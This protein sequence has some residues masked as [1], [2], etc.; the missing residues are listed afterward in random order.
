VNR[1]CS[2]APAHAGSLADF[3]LSSTLKMEAIRSSETSVNTLS[4]EHVHFVLR[5]PAGV[6]LRRRTHGASFHCNTVGS[7]VVDALWT[8]HVARHATCLPLD[9]CFRPVNLHPHHGPE[10]D[11]PIHFA[12]YIL[13]VY[14]MTTI[15]T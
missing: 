12:L 6:V 3:F 10:A 11:L 4:S 2:V 1:A 9:I 7:R 13:S 14:L 8:A 5:L 15:L